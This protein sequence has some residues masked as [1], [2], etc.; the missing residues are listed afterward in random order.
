[1]AEAEIKQEAPDH[2]EAMQH[3]WGWEGMLLEEY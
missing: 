2:K 1:M 3:A